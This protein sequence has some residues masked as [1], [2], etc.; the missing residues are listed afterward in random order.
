M[1]VDTAYSE[2]YT[3]RVLKKLLKKY[4]LEWLGSTEFRS[5][6]NLKESVDYCGQH[7]VELITYHVE[8]LMEENRSLEYVYE[9]ILEFKDFRDLLNYLSPHPYDTAESTFL[10]LLR[11]HEKITIV[12][13]RENDTFKFYLTDEISEYREETERITNLSVFFRSYIEI[14]LDI[15]KEAFHFDELYEFLLDQEISYD[16]AKNYQDFL[17]FRKEKAYSVSEILK[18]LEEEKIMTPKKIFIE[19]IKKDHNRFFKIIKDYYGLRYWN[20]EAEFRAYLKLFDNFYQEGNKN[21]LELGKNV[22]ELL[23]KVDKPEKEKNRL[24]K[25]INRV[26]ERG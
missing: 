6:F 9:K 20:P 1:Y 18:L 10:E 19:Q 8:S 25:T 11:N 22:L 16:S 14:L 7:K 13:H 23:E 24:E 5:T 12:E 17:Y 15:K 2:K 3:K 4:V 26:L 21:Y